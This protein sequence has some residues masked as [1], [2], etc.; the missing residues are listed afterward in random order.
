MIVIALGLL[1]VTAL[2]LTVAWRA[3]Y[4]D[5]GLDELARQENVPDEAVARVKKIS[6]V[7]SAF[8]TALASVSLISA[9]KILGV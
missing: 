6:K 1:C 2:T 5:D 4:C 7:A 9:L 8:F 3:Y